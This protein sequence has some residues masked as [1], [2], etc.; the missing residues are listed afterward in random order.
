MELT[1][2]VFDGVRFVNVDLFGVAVR[3]PGQVAQMELTGVSIDEVQFCHRFSLSCGRPGIRSSGLDGE[4]TQK[5]AGLKDLGAGEWLCEAY[6]IRKLS[7]FG[8]ECCG[9]VWLAVC[10]P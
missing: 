6:L 7:G 3:V 1:R 8:R 9:D 4:N 10:V 2:V 5:V